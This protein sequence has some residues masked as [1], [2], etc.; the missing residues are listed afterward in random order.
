[1]VNYPV[2]TEARES[3][4]INR[5]VARLPALR[6]VCVDDADGLDVAGHDGGS[7]IVIHPLVI[8]LS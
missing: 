5:F 2:N 3:L 7:S 4:I 6:V 1:M 8:R